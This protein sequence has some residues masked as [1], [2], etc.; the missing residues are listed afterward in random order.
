MS[1]AATA[2]NHRS[3]PTIVKENRH[4]GKPFRPDY[5][6]DPL[7]DNRSRQIE[8]VR[9]G[10]G[11]ALLIAPRRVLGTMHRVEIDTKSLTVT[12]ILGARQLTQALLSGVRPSPE[13]LAMGVWVD[14]VHAMTALGLAAADHTR[15]R[16]GLT[17]TAI[18]G[19]W[20]AAGYRDLARRQATA[21][22]HQRRRDKLAR[23]VLGLV[24]GGDIL[25]RQADTDRE[26]SL[27]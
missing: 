11:A 19:L 10:W 23:T 13:V 9:A 1:T 12:R 2:V 26:P 21:P 3:P 6:Q 4:D 15:A 5:E 24:P 22:A 8:L 20:A 17:D 18:A 25:L 14:T 16:A 7:S 27:P